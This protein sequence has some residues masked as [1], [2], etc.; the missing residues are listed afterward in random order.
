MYSITENIYCSQ[1]SSVAILLQPEPNCF[2]S[3]STRKGLG[4]LSLCAIVL[5][6][7]PPSHVST[8]NGQGRSQLFCVYCTWDS[9]QVASDQIFV[10]KFVALADSVIAL[11][12]ELN[13]IRFPVS[14]PFYEEFCLCLHNTS[15]VKRPVLVIVALCWMTAVRFPTATGNFRFTAGFVS[16]LG[17]T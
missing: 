5:R 16:T 3:C 13:G 17:V 7:S 8:C 2:T 1:L 9:S 15:D 4:S 12:R 6:A 10:G 14:A 11:S